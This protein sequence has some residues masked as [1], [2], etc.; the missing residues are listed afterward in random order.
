MV[1][2]Y[3]QVLGT[4]S[5]SEALRCQEPLDLAFTTS[6]TL[7]SLLATRKIAPRNVQL[8]FDARGIGTRIV[9]PP[10]DGSSDTVDDS[11]WTL[12]YQSR[13]ILFCQVHEPNLVTLLCKTPSP[14]QQHEDLHIYVV[15]TSNLAEANSLRDA[16]KASLDKAVEIKKS[17]AARNPSS[18]PSTQRNAGDQVSEIHPAHGKVAAAEPALSEQRE[19]QPTSPSVGQRKCALTPL[20]AVDSP[21]LAPPRGSSNARFLLAAVRKNTAATPDDA[22]DKDV[23]E[24][25]PTVPTHQ[26]AVQSARDS[27]G[28]DGDTDDASEG[29][30]IDILASL[31]GMTPQEEIQYQRSRRDRTAY[32]TRTTNDPDGSPVSTLHADCVASTQAH[33]DPSDVPPMKTPAQAADSAATV[34]LTVSDQASGDD[35]DLVSTATHGAEQRVQ[36]LHSISS[37]EAQ[38]KGS[39]TDTLAGESDAQNPH[40]NGQVAEELVDV[41]SEVH[42]TT[43]TETTSPQSTPLQSTPSGLGST[44]PSTRRKTPLLDSAGSS[45]SRLSSLRFWQR[46]QTKQKQKTPQER[47]Q[48]LEADTS[49]SSNFH[50]YNGLVCHMCG[51]LIPAQMTH[52]FNCSTMLVSP[53]DAL[54][55]PHTL[56]DGSAPVARC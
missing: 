11:K 3:V 16:L 23:T 51:M 44:S 24:T 30:A 21:P 26:D 12:A 20:S 14:E 48:T 28:S 13:H 53:I 47:L 17:N 37:I 31:T 2:F 22:S 34:P 40:H 42:T 49:A 15:R 43:T 39:G 41:S 55:T 54:A 32:S 9:P 4:R 29:E 38:Q 5:V 1:L 45:K 8:S 36:Q 7:Q 56:Y 46:K 33:S 10:P 25:S 52:C 18:R 35:C 27:N 6:M 19:L 50:L